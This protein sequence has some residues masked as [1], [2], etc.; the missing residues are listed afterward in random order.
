MWS[1]HFSCGD[2]GAPRDVSL[3]M[4]E[5][6]KKIT[7]FVMN[8]YAFV[9]FPIRGPTG[10]RLL[11]VTDSHSGTGSEPVPSSGVH[12]SSWFPFLPKI[13]ITPRGI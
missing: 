7:F 8:C 1:G 9:W 10:N 2:P 6:N 4:C 13:R 3:L 12:D 5:E 11:R